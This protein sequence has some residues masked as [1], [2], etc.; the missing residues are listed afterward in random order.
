V[1]VDDNQREQ[2]QGYRIGACDMQ[3][4]MKEVIGED[5]DEDRY[6]ALGYR[7]FVFLGEMIEVPLMSKHHLVQYTRYL[8]YIRVL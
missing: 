1:E 3:I 7:V 2:V 6:L 4:I 8:L 5:G